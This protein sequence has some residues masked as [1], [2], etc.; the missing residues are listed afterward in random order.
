MNDPAKT[1]QSGKTFLTPGGTETYMLFQQGFSLREGCAFEILDDEPA[2]ARLGRDYLAPIFS[3]AAA[4]GH[5]LLLDTLLWRAHP[6]F[7]AALGYPA[8]DLA[9]FNQL[10]V[11]RTREAVAQWRAGGPAG[12]N[13]EVILTADVGPRGDGYQVADRELTA[14][15]ARDYHRAQIEV[16]ARAG[17]DL[18]CALTMT[19]V[20]E[21]IGVTLAAREQGLPVIVSPTVETDGTLPDGTPLGEMI[22]RVEDATAGAPLLYMVNCAHPAHVEPTLAH[23]RANNA[24]WLRRFRGIRANSSRKSHAELDNSTELDRGNPDTLA[25]EVAGLHRAYD[26]TVVGGCCGTDAEHVAAIAA[27]TGPAPLRAACGA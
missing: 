8:I 21:A 16:L 1:L 5:G 24:D 9:R 25:R 14:E 27:A 13:L 3:A 15:A 12:A 2:W 10:G 19:S 20:A 6:D 17:V 26:L 11:E 23:A 18:V 22:R 4:H 7:V